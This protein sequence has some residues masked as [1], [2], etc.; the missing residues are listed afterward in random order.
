MCEHLKGDRLANVIANKNFHKR[1]SSI[2]LI[3]TISLC[4]G[5]SSSR[6]MILIELCHGI[7]PSFRHQN[8]VGRN[9]VSTQ[10]SLPSAPARWH[11]AV[12]TEITRSSSATSAAVS[13]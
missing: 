7:S 12:G 3:W 1:A 4:G 5:S 6:L 13:S 11:T 8:H 10:H 9:G 2:V